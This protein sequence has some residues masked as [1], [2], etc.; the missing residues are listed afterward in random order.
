MRVLWVEDQQ[1]IAESLEI[2]L[3]VLLP[4]ISLDKARTSESAVQLVQTFQYELVLMDWWMGGVDG[5]HLIQ[6]LRQVHCRAPIVVVSG[7]DRPELIDQAK[8]LGVEAFVSKSADTKIL[9][10][11]IEQ[12]VQQ[13]GSGSASAH[14][15]EPRVKPVANDDAVAQC[16]PGLTARQLEVF[17]CLMQGLADKQIANVLNIELT[18]ARTHVRAVLQAV[19]ASRRGEAV[20]LASMKGLTGV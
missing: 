20:Y 19:G 8:A 6:M 14:L 7:D 9:V 5:S 16:F 12:V 3:Q 17:K 15:V 18:T 1:L 10:N 13:V 4:Q 11:T 2:L